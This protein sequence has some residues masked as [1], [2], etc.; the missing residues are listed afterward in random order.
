MEQSVFPET[1]NAILVS[2]NRISSQKQQ[3]LKLVKIL[4]KFNLQIKRFDA[5]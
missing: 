1:H 2:G 3:I 5:K 4:Y